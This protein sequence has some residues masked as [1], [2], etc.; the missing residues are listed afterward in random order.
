[1]SSL[2]RSIAA[3]EPVPPVPALP[4]LEAG[5]FHASV[6]AF[7][8]QEQPGGGSYQHWLWCIS[9]LGPQQT[10]KALWAR[11][12]KGE[13]A[14]LSLETMRRVR[15]CRLAPEG[16]KGW[17]FFTASL[18]DAGGYQGVLVSEQA[19]FTS[20]RP[21]FLL[22]VRRTEQAP[23][24]H[25]RFLNRRVDLP[26]HA[27]WRYWLWDRACRTGEAAV[28]ETGGLIAYRCSPNPAAL[29]TEV[30]AA[31]RR[32]LLHVGEETTAPVASGRGEP[33]I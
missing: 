17:R 30:A 10:V 19:L 6:D 9:L 29:A 33:Q 13:L 28:L 4:V 26:L 20:E 7:A 11:L 8:L 14:T 22:L 2:H 24:L 15:F 31:V 1:M 32:R 27:S 16:P 5:G 18:P 21:D 23:M 3:R 12:L 25:Y